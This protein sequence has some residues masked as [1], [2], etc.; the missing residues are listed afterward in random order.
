MASDIEG[1]VGLAEYLG[2]RQ[3]GELSDQALRFL[4]VV[5]AAQRNHGR[6][7]RMWASS[8][9][10]LKTQVPESVRLV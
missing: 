8:A 5:R 7:G 3:A 9:A 2:T 4:I 1:I 6:A 10:W